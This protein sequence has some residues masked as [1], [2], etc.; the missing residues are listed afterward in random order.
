MGEF[1]ERFWEWTCEFRMQFYLLL[2]LDIVLLV[3]SL[4][5]LPFLE[6]GSAAYVL[7]WLDVGLFSV[8]LSPLLYIQYRCRSRERTVDEY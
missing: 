8:V 7:A 2:V 6:P 5:V 3:V 1:T 4:G